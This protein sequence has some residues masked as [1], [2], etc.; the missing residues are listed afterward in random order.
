M[1]IVSAAPL[2]AADPA[3]V[4]AA[5]DAACGC[6]AKGRE[7]MSGEVAGIPGNLGSM[8][9]LAPF[10]WPRLAKPQIHAA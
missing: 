1:L 5:A 9:S 3:A 8:R 7:G 10:F 4:A 2:L 6:A